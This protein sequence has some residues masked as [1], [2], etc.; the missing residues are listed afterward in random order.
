MGY[1]VGELFNRKVLTRIISEVNPATTR[2]S[3]LFGWNMGGEDTA[4]TNTLD[5]GGR[6]ANWDIFNNTREVATARQPEAVRAVRKPQ[7]SGSVHTVFPRVAEEI[8]L[9]YE[10]I[11]NLRDLGGPV[12]SQEVS[13]KG[14]TWITNQAKYL[15]QR[16]AN[17]IEFQTA[18]LLRGQYFYDA[19]GDDLVH[20]FTS[21]RFEVDYQVPDGNKLQLDMTGGGDIIDVSWDNAAADI[22][23]HVFEIDQAMQQLTGDRLTD[24][25]VPVD[26]WNHVLKNT[27]VQAQAGTANMP[28][29]DIKQGADDSF[30]GVVRALPWVRW[31]IIN[32][33]LNVGASETYTRL[34]QDGHAH[35]IPQPNS[36][37]TQ[38]YNGGEIVVDKNT[39]TK[40]NAVGSHFWNYENDNPAAQQLCGVHNGMPAL[41][42]SDNITDATVVF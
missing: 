34:I 8:Q 39:G 19:V 17:V 11:I 27:E 40:T 6:Q 12:D 30:V 7:K 9:L 24:V 16:I 33:G 23:L 35:F 13:P 18:A 37:W 22:P 36:Q 5:I 42:R 41:F 26:T 32:S 29:S 28:M 10:E 15:G 38:Y 2:L 20:S 21:G 4:G 3:K 25:I 31:H 14:E 1:T